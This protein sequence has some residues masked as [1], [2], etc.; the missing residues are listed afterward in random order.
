MGTLFLYGLALGAGLVAGVF[1]TEM[2][3]EGLKK[4]VGRY[5]HIG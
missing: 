1:V 3:F 4:L 5:V 2:L